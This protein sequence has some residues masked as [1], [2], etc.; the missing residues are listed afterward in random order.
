VYGSFS[1]IVGR[2]D[3]GTGAEEKCSHSDVLAF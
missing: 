3:V 1:V 2:F